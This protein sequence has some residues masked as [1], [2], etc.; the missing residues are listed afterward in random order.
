MASEE[1]VGLGVEGPRVKTDGR[2]LR[3]CRPRRHRVHECASDA[4]TPGF[5]GD[6][7]VVDVEDV[8]RF[9]EGVG[10]PVDVLDKDIAAHLVVYDGDG[11]G[12]ALAVEAAGQV[13]GQILCLCVGKEVRSSRDVQVLHL[14]AQG[15]ERREVVPGSASQADVR[16]GGLAV[17]EA[18]S[19]L[20]AEEAQ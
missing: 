12:E 8:F 3:V 4:S 16:G 13:G 9:A 15:R 5:P 18:P 2:A 7:D 19:V 20:V 11:D 14:T 1:R 6:A 10:G 17:R